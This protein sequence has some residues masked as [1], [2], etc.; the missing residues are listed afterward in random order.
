MIVSRRI[1]HFPRANCPDCYQSTRRNYWMLYFWCDSGKK[2]NG[3]FLLRGSAVTNIGRTYI[4][5]GLIWLVVGTI[6]GTWLGASNHLQ[7]ANAHAHTNLLGFVSSVLFGF[8]YL[9][10]PTMQKSRLALP[11][12][13]L[14]EVGTVLLVI[15]KYYVGDGVDIPP[16]LI[17]GSLLIIVGVILM[18]V[19]FWKHSAN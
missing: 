14:F 15:G 13:L 17:G 12:L 3:G 9:T 4:V 10:Y 5:L 11:Q 16:L 19:L 18:L 1:W 8:M 2:A 6:F 7:Y